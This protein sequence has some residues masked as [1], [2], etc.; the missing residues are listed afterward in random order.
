MKVSYSWLKEYLPLEM[1]AGDLAERLP[2]IGF[3]VAGQTS[4][5]PGFSGVV[6]AQILAIA[7]HP[8]ADRLSLCM[9]DDGKRKFSVVCGAGNIAVG[10]KIPLAKIGALLP[11]GRQITR[12]KIRGVESE[13][14]ICSSEELGLGAQSNGGGILVMDPQTEL[15]L[16]VSRSLGPVDEILDI[17]ISPNRPDCLSHFGLARELAAYFRLPLIPLAAPELKT[18]QGSCLPVRVADAQACPRYLGRILTNLKIG[19]SPGWLALKL[20]AVGLRPIN[21]LVDITNYILMDIGQPLHAFDLDLLAGTQIAVRFASEGETIKALDNKDYALTPSCLVIADAEKPV[22]VAGVMGGLESAVTVKTTRAFLESAYFDPIVVRKT[23]AALRLRSDSSYR[24]ERGAD[25]AMVETASERAA[26][27][28]LKLCGKDAQASPPLNVGKERAETAPILVTTSRINEILGADFPDEAIT[29][30]L[31]SIDPGL[32]ERAGK[33]LHF[34]PPSCRR[35]LATAWDL[36]EEIGRLLGYEHIPAKISS[37]ALRPS[38]AA[39][40]QTIAERCRQRLAALGL[41]EAYNYDFLSEKLLRM[42][43]PDDKNLARIANPLSEDWTT[44]RP[45]LLIGLLQNAAANLNRGTKSV[46][47]FELG[48]TYRKTPSGLEERARAAAIL[49]GPVAPPFWGPQKIRRNDFYDTKGVVLDL[50]AYIP[51]LAL[52]PFKACDPL[53]HPGASLRLSTPKGVLGAL[54][55]LHPPIARAWGLERENASIFELDLDLLAELEPARF[56]FSPYSRHPSAARDLSVVVDKKIPY[57]DVAAVL[58]GCAIAELKSLELVDLFE[59]RGVPKGKQSLTLRLTFGRLDRAL[60]D[61][62][63]NAA[64]EKILAALKS[65]LKAVLR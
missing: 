42:A 26:G 52:V 41:C 36:S 24:F 65:E 9:V 11:G 27:L 1:S 61:V 18:P 57:A 62:E 56:Q 8:N 4:R 7:K 5:G 49:L 58:R 32:E 38:R 47:L 2:M 40:G 16:D 6:A 59:G 50:L 54:G 30:T 60:T 20:E 19:P 31:R 34:S 3:E 14:M 64:V 13:G 44:L 63:V 12:A 37:V 15:G 48:K 28:I 51:G 55:L 25:I 53:F 29:S 21:N 39:P 10:Q 35:D 45:T 17:E 46:R 43:R 23:S 22:A 33:T